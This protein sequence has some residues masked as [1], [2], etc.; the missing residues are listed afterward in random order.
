MKELSSET[1]NRHLDEL[2]A[3]EPNEF[4][5]VSLYL[6]TQADQHGRDNFAPFVRKEFSR[7]AKTFPVNS[8]DDKQLRRRKIKQV[9]QRQKPGYF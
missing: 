3:F 2:A 7:R 8:P 4:P 5:F 6:N 1:L 9:L